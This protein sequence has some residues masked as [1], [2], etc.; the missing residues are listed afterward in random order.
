MSLTIET[1]I[2]NQQPQ[3]MSSDV[4]KIIPADKEERFSS[5]SFSLEDI[6]R[7]LL[8]PR[9]GTGKCSNLIAALNYEIY[10]YHLKEQK[11]SHLNEEQIL[12][13]ETESR[14]CILISDLKGLEV[15]VSYFGPDCRQNFSRQVVAIDT[16]RNEALVVYE[17]RIEKF[18]LA[19]ASFVDQLIIKTASIPSDRQ[20]NWEINQTVQ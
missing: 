15:Y 18:D 5:G 19:T 16:A 17:E 7:G 12:K 8:E 11:M 20:L 13:Q 10:D 2:V 14:S 1:L 9:K 6:Q 3:D 4:W